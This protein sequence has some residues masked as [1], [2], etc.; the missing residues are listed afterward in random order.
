M[1]LVV[2]TALLE[3]LAPD[4]LSQV[5]LDAA[6]DAAEGDVNQA[7]LVLWWDHRSNIMSGPLSWSAQGDYSEDR[8]KNVY[9]VNKII[10][11]LEQTVGVGT[12]ASGIDTSQP[13]L[14]TAPMRRLGR[15]TL[16]VGD[17]IVSTAS[18]TVVDVS[19]AALWAKLQA[20]ADAVTQS[21][22]V[23]YQDTDIDLVADTPLVVDVSS[24]IGE[25]VVVQILD[26]LD[27][28]VTSG[29]EVTIEYGQVTLESGTNRNDYTLNVLGH[30]PV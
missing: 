24:T 28:E 23:A 1:A 21:N 25:I 4:G 18:S 27:M 3:S 26:D 12:S 20:I 7:A 14:G 11:G 29:I 17:P 16:Y 15:E 30:P 6:Y 10:S 13:M 8:T 5:T 22:L 9:E 19:N 2:S